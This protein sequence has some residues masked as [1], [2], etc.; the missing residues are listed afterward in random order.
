VYSK[1]PSEETSPEYDPEK[2]PECH[3]ILMYVDDL[4]DRTTDK[5][6]IYN[7]IQLSDI[8]QYCEEFKTAY[9]NTLELLTRTDLSKLIDIVSSENYWWLLPHAT[10]IPEPV[11]DAG[12]S[13]CPSVLPYSQ[14]T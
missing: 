6:E 10:R 4:W 11:N 8:A 13:F 14:L 5:M 3:P 1:Y 12:M 2:C 9:P 7:V